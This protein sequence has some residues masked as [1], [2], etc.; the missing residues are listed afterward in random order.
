MAIVFKLQ[1]CLRRP[2]NWSGR[3]QSI[4]VTYGDRKSVRLYLKVRQA[5]SS[6]EGKP[7][8][9]RVSI[10]F[11]TSRASLTFKRCQSSQH[12]ETRQS[13]APLITMLSGSFVMD[14]SSQPN[15]HLFQ[16]ESCCM[17]A[18]LYWCLL[19]NCPR[20]NCPH[21]SSQLDC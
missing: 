19:A 15:L 7:C 12:S 3:Q 9:L 8:D 17:L 4:C 2:E 21:I 6:H 10:S 11:P 14:T 5:R 16:C 18:Y 20:A 13:Y 1:H